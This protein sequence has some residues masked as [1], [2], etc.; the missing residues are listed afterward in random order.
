MSCFK[1]DCMLDMGWNTNTYSD[2]ASL[3]L[4]GTAEQDNLA[5]FAG[6]LVTSQIIV[7]D[8]RSR[9]RRED[10]EVATTL[11]GKAPLAVSEDVFAC[12]CYSDLS[13]LVYRC[14]PQLVLN[15]PALII[16]CRSVKEKSWSLAGK[17]E[18]HTDQVETI[19]DWLLIDFRLFAILFNLSV[20]QV[21]GLS[22]SSD[23]TK[24][25]SCGWDGLLCIWSLGSLS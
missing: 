20:I 25:A 6:N 10:L 22:I 16:V 23:G 4:C 14:E 8:L 19:L 1:W 15:S 2:V 12:A 11:P 13:I 9:R 17:L 3:A 7:G 5:V 21:T 18:Y 24:L